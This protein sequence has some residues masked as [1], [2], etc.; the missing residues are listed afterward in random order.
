MTADSTV[1]HAVE[2][3]ESR[4]GIL[5]RVPWALLVLV[6]VVAALVADRVYYLRNFGAVYTEADQTMLWYQADDLAHGIF[7]EPC[8]YGQAYNVPVEAWVAV[9]LLWAGV[10][11]AVAL[12]VATIVLGLVPFFVL[13]GIA[14]GAG[15]RW[16]AVM[17]WLIPL[18]LPVEYVVVTSIPRGFVGGIAIGSVAVGIWLVGRSRVAF[19]AAGLFSVVAV[20]VNPNSVVLLLAGGCMRLASHFRERRFYVWSVV[21][22]FWGRRCRS[23]S[24]ISTSG[25]RHRMFSGRSRR[26]RFTGRCCGRR[27]WL[28]GI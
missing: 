18:A 23:I 11:H 14:L 26:W 27:W 4:A 3:P 22:G 13:A 17:I 16:G 25:I 20:A 10:R 21:G 15:R 2:V 12:P 8:Y 6:V 9:P 5:S 24:T 7:R 1:P 19:V 28:G